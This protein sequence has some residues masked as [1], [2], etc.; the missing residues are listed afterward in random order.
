MS[1]LPKNHHL[2]LFIHWMARRADQSEGKFHEVSQIVDWMEATHEKGLRLVPSPDDQFAREHPPRWMKS[3]KDKEGAWKH[4]SFPTISLCVADAKSARA[5]SL[6]YGPVGLCID[7]NLAIKAGAQPVIYFHRSGTNVALNASLQA[8]TKHISNIE[9]SSDLIR[10]WSFLLGL[11][12]PLTRVRKKTAVQR[13]HAEPKPEKR[14]RPPSAVPQV[15]LPRLNNY[16]DHEW[17]ICIDPK[18]PPV[19]WNDELSRLAS[20]NGTWI[21]SLI[22]RTSRFADELHREIDKRERSSLK[23]L[24]IKNLSTLEKVS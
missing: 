7:Q 24:T 19:K 23:G 1:E 20:P 16:L 18:N 14:S 11:M 4:H 15:R 21:E 5:A 10:H 13:T 17:R 3:L 6:R 2:P 12:K 8:I 9:D 22:A